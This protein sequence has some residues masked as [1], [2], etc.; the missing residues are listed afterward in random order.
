V[1][2]IATLVGRYYA[3]DRDNRWERL[4]KAFRLLRFTEGRREKEAPEKALARAYEQGETDEFVQPIVLDPSGA[5]RDGDS[6]IFFNFRPDR[7]RQITRAFI[8]PNFDAFNRGSAPRVTFVS[9]APY[10]DALPIPTAFAPDET[11]SLILGETFAKQDLKQLRIAETEKYAHVTYF[12]NNGREAP[13]ANEDRVLIPSPRVATYD[14][15]PEMSAYEVTAKAIAR[16]E[17]G[18][19]DFVLL[20]YANP[21]M[22][23]HT[24]VYEAAVKACEAVDICLGELVEATLRQNGELLITADHGNADIMR[25][26]R[27]EPH[28]AHTTSPGPLI[29][30]GSRDLAL[31]DGGALCDVSPTMLALMGIPQPKE[32]TGRNLLT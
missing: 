24:G 6:V 28:T 18:Q 14:L 4:E 23:G 5:I 19:Y 26:A 32:M 8:D 9:M 22:V 27:G 29:Y 21:D 16:I 11:L 13:F 7:A 30:V 3:M 2:E 17:S 31:A 25:D 1:G 12:F 20:N 10:D 15:K